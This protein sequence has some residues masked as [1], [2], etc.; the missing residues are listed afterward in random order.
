MSKVTIN[1]TEYN[2]NKMSDEAK[3]RVEAIQ[4]CD[5]KA[6]ELRQELAIMQTARNAYVAALE[7]ITAESK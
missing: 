6:A 1:N 7:G 2:L 5:R 4:V 3:A